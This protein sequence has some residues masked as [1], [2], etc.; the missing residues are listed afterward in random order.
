[1]PA[2][3]ATAIPP[4]F[5]EAVMKSPRSP[6]R[7]SAPQAT[8]MLLSCL[9]SVKPLSFLEVGAAMGPT[10]SKRASRPIHY[11]ESQRW[12]SA[13]GGP[14]AVPHGIGV[15]LPRHHRPPT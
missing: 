10:S 11:R 5:P 8:D 9:E 2:L 3:A 15:G 1:M 12:C 6:I 14:S 13:L 4:G 7:C